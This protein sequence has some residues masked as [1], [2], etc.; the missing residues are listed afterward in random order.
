MRLLL[1]FLDLLLSY[2]RGLRSSFI[3][4]IQLYL[5]LLHSLRSQFQWPC[6]DADSELFTDFLAVDLE[7]FQRVSHGFFRN[8]VLQ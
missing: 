7:I 8:S 3:S 6:L 1:F 5:R 4:F 2:S